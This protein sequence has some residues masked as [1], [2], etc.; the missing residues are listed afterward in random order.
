MRIIHTSDWHIGLELNGHNRLDEQAEFLKWLLN[1]CF[2]LRIDALLI[3]GDIYD[4]ANPTVE[5]QALFAKFATEF[6]NKLPKA[7]LVVIA[8]NHD[9]GGRME[10]ARP[11]TQAL[12]GIHMVGS[13][14]LNDSDRF[15]KHV[16]PLCDADGLPGAWCLAVPFLRA[17]DLDCKKHESETIEQAFGRSISAKYS[18]LRLQAVSLNPDLPII[19]MGH[20]TTLGCEKAGSERILIG[21]VESIPAA[22]LS[23]GMDYVALGHIHKA[24]PIGVK[25]NNAVDNLKVQYCGS[26][27]SMTFDERKYEHK[28]LLVEISKPGAEIKVTPIPIPQIV[29]FI[30][31]SEDI[32]SWNEVVSDIE[33]YD[34][35]T[36]KDTTRN[37]Q[38][39]VDIHFLNEGN[40][41]D[42]RSKV[43]EL[44]KKF[45]FRL[46]GSPRRVVD[47]K[48]NIMSEAQSSLAKID[49]SSVESPLEVFEKYYSKKYQ[50]AL[51][52]ELKDCFKE[53]LDETLIHREAK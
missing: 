8:G 50:A 1:R 33:N 16:I 42:I 51:P 52:V 20:L 41:G 2:E 35:S 13:L 11:Y 4:V 49:L 21:G 37:L 14:G 19:A 45:P 36:W 31:F 3:A 40:L 29:A 24:Q 5:A 23:E 10:I 26:P 22:N 47:E 30:R 28:I 17:S 53:I 18:E 39:F 38:P 34:W 12:G 6:K 25:K 15:S 43:D 44:I 9:S 27:L 46:V 7:S 32:K 48:N